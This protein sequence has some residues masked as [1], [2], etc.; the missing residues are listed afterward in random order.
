MI[1]NAKI[2]T[3]ALLLLAAGQGVAR[4]VTVSSASAINKTW[5]AGD[6]LV[7]T[8][9]TYSNQNLT[10][11]GNGTSAQPIVLYAATP[12]S[13]IL[14][15]SSTITIK[16]KYIEVQ[17]IRF[18]GKY[19][20]K[21][22][23]VQFDSSS[24]DCRL[25]ECSIESYN[26][27]DVT[28]DY[29]WVS[30]KGKRNRVD[31]CYFAGKTNMGTLLVVWLEE[32]IIPKHQIDN[33]YFGYR[34]TNK[35]SDGK[36]LNGQEIIRIGDSSTS[37]QEAQCIVERNYF[38]GCDG[39][40]EL[41]SN[42]S[43][44]NIYRNNTFYAC[45]GTLTLR[46]GNGCTVEG[47]WFFG[48]GKDATGGV[49]IIGE[50]HKVI[51][52]YFQDLA[53]NNYRAGVCIVRGKPNSALN[54]YFQVKNATVTG[55]IFVNC[56]E[57]ICANY[58]SSSDCNL[59]AL[60][61]TIENNQVYND[62]A[63]KNN[64]VVMLSASGGSLTWSGNIYKAGKFSSYTPSSS[65]WEQVSDMQQPEPIADIPSADNSGPAWRHPM[66]PTETVNVQPSELMAKKILLN[67]QILIINTDCNNGL[68]MRYSISG[69]KL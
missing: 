30:I 6:T 7:F 35:G 54:E 33:N 17:G 58:H 65:E 13:V 5:S 18:D 19:T 56:K 62:N 48:T 2:I 68:Q 67:G 40:T 43:C 49:R 12:G 20:G 21:S 4:T 28:K 57:A 45:A 11:S 25:T 22:H 1:Q 14:T 60:N 8:N 64:R 29:K 55:N 15:G 47:N 26:T 63:Y 42:K 41:I 61:T 46:H 10:L 66:T 51:N 50:N 31:H 39:E 59:P 27:D 36:A 23:I 16:G 38:E 34:D 32:D 44:G 52:N 9:G 53:G 24:S 69:R 37:M 3:L